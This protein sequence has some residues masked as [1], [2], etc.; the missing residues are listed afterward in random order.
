[1]LPRE[2]DKEEGRT[3]RGRLIALVNV[4][5][6]RTL[7]LCHEELAVRNYG[8]VGAVE[9]AASSMSAVLAALGFSKWMVATCFSESCSTLEILPQKLPSENELLGYKGDMNVNSRK[10][11]GEVLLSGSLGDVGDL[12]DSASPYSSDDLSLR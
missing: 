9:V 1:M 7:V 3:A 11:V 10:E 6:I 12:E 2:G 4:A 5:L 8:E